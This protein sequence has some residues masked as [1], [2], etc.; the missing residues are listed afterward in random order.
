MLS[1]ERDTKETGSQSLVLGDKK[2][3]ETKARR[4]GQKPERQD[5]QLK[6]DGITAGFPLNAVK[7]TARF[8]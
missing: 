3:V 5:Q 7:K 4:A 8:L 6:E 1:S 2:A